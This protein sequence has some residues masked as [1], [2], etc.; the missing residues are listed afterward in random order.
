M[1]APFLTKA[2]EPETVPSIVVLVASPEVMTP[3]ST[4]VPL[5]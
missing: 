1:P 3:L 2:P 4:I 5:L